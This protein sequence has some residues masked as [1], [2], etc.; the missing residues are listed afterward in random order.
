MAVIDRV[1]S[2]R[3]RGVIPGHLVDKGVEGVAIRVKYGRS[4]PSAG[5]IPRLVGAARSR[6]GIFDVLMVAILTE[7]NRQQA[8]RAVIMC[9]SLVARVVL[10]VQ[11]ST[12]REFTATSKASVNEVAPD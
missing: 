2:T 10:S 11:A 1:G 6:V 8:V 3:G 12:Y 7:N 5:K 4:Q 9:T